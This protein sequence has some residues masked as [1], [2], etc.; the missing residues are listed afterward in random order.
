M[1][2]GTSKIPPRSFLVGAA[3]AMEDKIYKMAGRAV[4]AALLGKGLASAEMRELLHLLHHVGHAAGEAMD[5]ALEG[6]G[7]ENKGRHR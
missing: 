1:E 3:H 6:P 2:L 7:D 5:K 4:V